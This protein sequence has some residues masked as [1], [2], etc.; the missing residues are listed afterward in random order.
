MC[1]A[2]RLFLFRDTPGDGRVHFPGDFGVPVEPTLGCDPLQKKKPTLGA[3]CG[4]PSADGGLHLPGKDGYETGERTDPD[5]N[6]VDAHAAWAGITAQVVFPR[7]RA[8]AAWRPRATNGLEGIWVLFG[9]DQDGVPVE[10][11]LGCDPLREKKGL[12]R[13]SRQ[14][15]SWR[16][17]KDR[18]LDGR[19]GPRSSQYQGGAGHRRLRVLQGEPRGSVCP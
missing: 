17:V 5:P 11:T 19:P 1:P 8:R 3:P 14:K 16:E 12:L 9:P 15:A 18:A 2:N 4:G 10:P 7:Q 6:T 13:P